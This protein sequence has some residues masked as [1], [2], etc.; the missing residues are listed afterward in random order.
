MID[1]ILNTVTNVWAE[2]FM[3]IREYCTCSNDVQN[4]LQTGSEEVFQS[5][6][7]KIHS[8]EAQQPNDDIFQSSDLPHV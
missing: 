4:F 8:G 3:S 5:V 1:D 7:Y 6:Y 2:V